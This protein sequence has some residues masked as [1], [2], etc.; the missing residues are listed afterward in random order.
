MIIYIQ[1]DERIARFKLVIALTMWTVILVTLYSFYKEYQLN[2]RL[3]FERESQQIE[4]EM[5]KV[6]YPYNQGVTEVEPEPVVEPEVVTTTVDNR[7]SKV[8][9]FL[10]SRNAPLAA[11]AEQFVISA[12]K[13]GIDYRLV[14]A[15]SIIE[16]S[17]GS[18]LFRP[19]NAWG[20]GSVNFSSF[21]EG[22]DT[23]SRGLKKGYYNRGLDTPSE[24]AP[25]YCPP[26]ASHW[27][28]AVSEFMSQ[29]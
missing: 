12:D 4:Q 19:Y 13:Y 27:A 21:D 18:K 5:N 26:N 29:M 20:W 2:N 7:V 9:S 11:H 23:V 25:V 14:A 3:E 16:S 24:I 8:R 28:S 22:I 1:R 10:V 17:G 15:I 6:W